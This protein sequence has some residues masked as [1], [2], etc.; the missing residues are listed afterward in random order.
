MRRANP[1]MPLLLAIAG[2]SCDGE[3]PLTAPEGAEL[4]I[5]A[6]PTS[7]PVFNGVST[8]TVVGFKGV[9]DGGGPLSDGT[10]IFLTSN[11]GVIEERVEIQ[12]GVARASLL[13]NG[14]AGLATVSARSGAGIVATLETPVL[15]GNAEGINILLTAN[16]P[17]LSPPDFTSELVA[18]VFD[19]N[20]NRM[21]D[22]PIIFTTSAG[23]L[24]SAGTSLRTNANGQ[25]FD[26]L[27]LL[28]ETTATVT[29]FSGAVTS[30][31]VTVNR[32]TS[33]D[34]IVNSVSP[35]SGSPGETL[36]VTISGANFQPGATV[37]FGQGIATNSVNFVDSGTLIA[38]ITIDPS[39]VITTA[40][41]TVTVTNPDGGSGSLA[42]AFLVTTP[43][44]AP[45]PFI[46]SVSPPSTATRG[47]AITLTISGT[48]FQT[49]SLVSFSPGGMIINGI[50]V[51]S[52]TQIDVS[53]TVP[54]STVV[55]PPGTQF[56]ITVRNLDGGQDTLPSA[57]TVT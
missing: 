18:T 40:G 12:N 7:I 39:A 36:S 57:F 1:W 45:A 21:S 32:G 49:G 55:V 19:N 14:R 44:A 42:D 4:S 9:E 29:A 24:A 20:N 3:V 34:P 48:D 50:N 6:N 25:A 26:R 28:N 30:N 8:I 47:V 41:R 46:L 17:T 16:P 33:V 43:G 56:D 27:T 51:V 35:S 10:Q 11:V 13:S 23:S 52:A 53:I 54:S 22:V 38:N 15:I 37:S 2:W 5:T 31:A